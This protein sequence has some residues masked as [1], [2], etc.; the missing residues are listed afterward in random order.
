MAEPENQTLR[1]LRDIREMLKDSEKRAGELEKKVD[2]NHGELK[3]RLD[4]IRQALNGESIL[5]RYAVAEVDERLAA[6]EKR[7]KALEGRR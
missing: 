5:G 4:N 1:I 2:R 6:L 7:V 3:S